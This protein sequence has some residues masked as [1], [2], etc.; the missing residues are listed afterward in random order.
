M[1]CVWKTDNLGVGDSFFYHVDPGDYTQVVMLVADVFILWTFSPTPSIL[2]L[3]LSY[4]VFLRH[5][6][7]HVHIFIFNISLWLQFKKMVKLALISFIADD[8]SSMASLK[9]LAIKVILAFWG[10]CHDGT[11]Y[12]TVFHC[13][14]NHILLPGAGKCGPLK[15]FQAWR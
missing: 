7:L 5:R 3:T 8:V 13:I 6:F 12:I 15:S 2:F 14:T 11:S 9:L 4:M 10:S 1:A